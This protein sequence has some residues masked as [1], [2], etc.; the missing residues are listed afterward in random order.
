M[1]GH[2][3]AATNSWNRRRSLILNSKLH[4]ALDRAS[5]G[6]FG[7]W[8]N[9]QEGC[10]EVL[11]SER[12]RDQ[13]D[14]EE[15]RDEGSMEHRLFLGP[16]RLQNQTVLFC[17]LPRQPGWLISSSELVDTGKEAAG[18][19]EKEIKTKGKAERHGRSDRAADSFPL[20][21]YLSLEEFRRFYKHR[22]VDLLGC[23]CHHAVLLS[24]IEGSLHGEGKGRKPTGVQLSALTSRH[25]TWHG[26]ER[27]WPPSS[28]LKLGDY[29][30]KDQPHIQVAIPFLGG[31]RRA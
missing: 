2:H 6:C 13:L 7:E 29:S 28:P 31:R 4:F 22:A 9:T 17:L 26:T 25:V 1:L 12:E 27:N 18:G 30:S 16:Q 15:E 5:L 23:G 21:P 3:P 10:L 19:A 20:K 14:Q 11:F 24:G 8:H